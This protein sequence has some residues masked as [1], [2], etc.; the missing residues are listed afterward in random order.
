[1][2]HRANR[3]ISQGFGAGSAGHRS[4]TSANILLPKPTMFGDQVSSWGG[5]RM[6]REVRLTLVFLVIWLLV[7]MT[8]LSVGGSPAPAYIG[9]VRSYVFHR[10]TCHHLPATKNRTYFHTRKEA[11]DAGY[12]PCRKCKP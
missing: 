1:M 7:G 2:N 10:Q 9:N 11:I 3:R 4:L 12:R 6:E 5:P 8:G